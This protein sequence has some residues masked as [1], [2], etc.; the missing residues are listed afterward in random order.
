MS[1]R[2]GL[3]Q[4]IHDAPDDLHLR[5][6]FADWLEEQGTPTDLAQSEF[7]RLQLEIEPIR[8]DYES[9]RAETLCRREKELLEQH[10]AGLARGGGRARG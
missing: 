10:C 3:L 8:D 9:E 2:S 1:D 4:A 7:I 5:L 6:V